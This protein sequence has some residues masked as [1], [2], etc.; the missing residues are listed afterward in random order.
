MLGH[1]LKGEHKMIFISKTLA[2]LADK[3]SAFRKKEDGLTLTEYVVTLGLLTAAVIGAV[4][5]FGDALGETWSN[6]AFFIQSETGPVDA[7]GQAVVA[8][9]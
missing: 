8:P 9:D 5:A 1:E 4:I 7:D 3:A 2:K 6:W